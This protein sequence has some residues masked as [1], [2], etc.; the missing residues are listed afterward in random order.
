MGAGAL[1]GKRYSSGSGRG[2]GM[3]S[4]TVHDSEKKEAERRP[5]S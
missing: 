2:R 3:R 5:A 1:Q 4:I